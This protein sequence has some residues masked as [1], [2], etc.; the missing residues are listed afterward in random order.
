MSGKIHGN[1]WKIRNPEASPS[2]IHIELKIE[3]A[4]LVE[5]FMIL[6]TIQI[7][8]YVEVCCI[9]RYKYAY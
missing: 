3:I 6:Y 7:L 9:S 5:F 8:E 2:L 1:I 4:Y